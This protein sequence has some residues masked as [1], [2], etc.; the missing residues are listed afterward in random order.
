MSGFRGAALLLALLVLP[1]GA[2]AVPFDVV[3]P[4]E[5]Q[6]DTTVP[7]SGVQFEYWGWVVA[8]TDTIQMDDLFM[9]E[10]AVE[11]E[12][13]D[14]GS[15]SIEHIAFKNIGVFAP[16]IPGEV[17]G[18]RLDPEN[19]AAYDSLLSGETMKAP[20]TPFWTTVIGYTTGLV[21]TLTVTG[22]VILGGD[23]LSYATTVYFGSFGVLPVVALGQRIPS[24]P[25]MVLVQDTTWGSLKSMYLKR[26]P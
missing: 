3:V 20:D 12:Q 8:T 10:I 17:A 18:F 4:Q 5:I 22:S 15:T 26:D 7:S 6:I 2:A 21:D 16:L 24:T 13:P 23:E 19:A 14:S 1:V 11:I 25:I 9:A